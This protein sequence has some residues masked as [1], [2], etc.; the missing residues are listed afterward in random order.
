MKPILVW[1]ERVFK[2]RSKESAAAL[3]VARPSSQ[4][5]R[6]HSIEKMHPLSFIVDMAVKRSNNYDS[7]KM[8]R[9]SVFDST[10]SKRLNW[11]YPRLLCLIQ[12]SDVCIMI[13]D[14]LHDTTV[15]CWCLEH[16]SIRV[17]RK[18]AGGSS[19]EKWWR[20]ME[21][22]INSQPCALGLFP[23]LW[24]RLDIRN[25][26]AQS[27]MAVRLTFTRDFCRCNLRSY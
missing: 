27:I 20:S 16:D 17:I 2:E 7:V 22:L 6:Y 3:S 19:F 11:E 1:S 26:L 13:A 15:I 18:L 23:R 10:W 12:N 5:L 14:L 24:R 9:K 4:H 25:Q 8:A 21:Y